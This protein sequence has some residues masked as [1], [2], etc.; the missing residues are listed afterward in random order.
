M[1]CKAFSEEKYFWMSTCMYYIRNN[2]C[3]LQLP[4]SNQRIKGSRM[5]I[6]I[7]DN[8]YYHQQKIFNVRHI[9]A[10]MLLIHAGWEKVESVEVT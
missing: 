8:G 4:G 1:K 3:I 2:F 9:W 10:F 7:K 6:T 5:V